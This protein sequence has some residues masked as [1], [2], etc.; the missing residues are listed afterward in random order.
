MQRIRVVD[1]PV[2]ASAELSERLLNA[3]YDAGYYLDQL[4]SGRGGGIRAIYRLRMRQAQ[5]PETDAA[6]ALVLANPDLSNR[7]V[8]ALL[9]ERGIHRGKDWVQARRNAAARAIG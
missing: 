6:T 8:C 5:A 2:D 7:K 3:P 9:A 4:M 1:V